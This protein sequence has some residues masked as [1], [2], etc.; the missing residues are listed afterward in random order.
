MLHHRPGNHVVDSGLQAALDNIRAIEDPEKRDIAETMFFLGRQFPVLPARP[1]AVVLVHGIRTYGEWQ[2]KLKHMLQEA[3]CPNVHVVGYERFDL[4][5]FLCPFWTRKRAI[6]RVLR[7]IRT[8]R[9]I[10]GDPHITVVAHSFGTYILSKILREETDVVLHRLLLCG[11]VIPRAYRWDQVASRVSETPILNDVGTRDPWP[12]VARNV[13]WGYG[14][15]GTFGFATSHVE[16]RFHD[17]GHSDFFTED[18]MRRYWLPFVLDGAIISSP[19][20]SARSKPS[21]KFGLLRVC[22]PSLLAAITAGT[23]F[24]TRIYHILFALRVAFT[25][26]YS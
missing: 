20:T 16:D 9:A 17:F 3:G 14:P 22:S 5:R 13:T 26:I 10:H 23:A 7:E 2:W 6:N 21:W 4:P 15:S 25:R 12:V 1:H 8:V 11:S 24:H 19:W 18:H